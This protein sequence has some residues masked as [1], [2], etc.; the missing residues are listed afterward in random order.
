MKKK[1]DVLD[2]NFIEGMACVGGCIGGAGCLTHGEKNKA[3]VDK[4][5]K[6]ALEKNI[7]D[8]VSIL[9]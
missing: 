3:E 1:K 9:K 2:A 7:S 4:Y 5:G 8:A 6:E